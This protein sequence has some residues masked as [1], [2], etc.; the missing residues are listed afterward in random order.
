[1][2]EWK[3][4]TTETADSNYLATDRLSVPGGWIYRSTFVLRDGG[5]KI[6]TVFVPFARFNGDDMSRRFDASPQ[7]PA[8]AKPSGIPDFSQP[9]PR[10]G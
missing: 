8:N 3:D 4:V 9:V 7:N 5:V 10:R 2:S 1:M 6:S